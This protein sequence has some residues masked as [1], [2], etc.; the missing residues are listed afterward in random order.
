MRECEDRSKKQTPH[1]SENSSCL[2][3]QVQLT[4]VVSRSKQRLAPTSKVFC[5]SRPSVKLIDDHEKST[6]QAT[7][8]TDDVGASLGLS[9]LTS[10]KTVDLCQQ[11]DTCANSTRLASLCSSERPRS[12]VPIYCLR[13]SNERKSPPNPHTTITKAIRKLIIKASGI[14][15][16]SIR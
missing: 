4:K 9:K 1:H 2:L 16:G 13:Q 10:L 11:C 5:L 14:F 12:E 6:P 8:M 7:V 15:W 3:A